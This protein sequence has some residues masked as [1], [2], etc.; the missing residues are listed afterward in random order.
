MFDLHILSL[1]LIMFAALCFFGPQMAV[2][3]WHGAKGMSQN[4]M[5]VGVVSI[6][7]LISVLCVVSPYFAPAVNETGL[8][9]EH[10]VIQKRFMA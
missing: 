8:S 5:A 1:A 10:A 6:L 2:Y 7:L 3:G 4:A 9:A